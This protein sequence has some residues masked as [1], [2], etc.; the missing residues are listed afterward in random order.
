M[1]DEKR[2]TGPAQPPQLPTTLWRGAMLV[3]MIVIMFNSVITMTDTQRSH[4]VL[5]TIRDRVLDIRRY[6]Q[7]LELELAPR[8]PETPR[9][10]VPVLPDLKP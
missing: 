10:T 6:T 5:E 7:N 1:T 9:K 2:E 3:M 8:P 4:H